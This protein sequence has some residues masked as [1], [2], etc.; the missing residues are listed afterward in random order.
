M[1]SWLLAEA[2]LGKRPWT[3]IVPEGVDDLTLH[4]PDREF[5]AQLKSRHDPKAVFD[6]GEVARFLAK[7][8]L[9]LPEG[10]ANDDRYALAVV[11]ERPV[12]GLEAGDFDRTIGEIDQDLSPLVTALQ[13][14]LPDGFDAQALLER[15]YL[16][17]EANPIRGASL[18]LAQ[19]G[20]EPAILNIVAQML[21]EAAGKA[22]DD[23]YRAGAT[24]VAMLGRTDV[25]AR[26]DL[27]R[28]L[29]DPAGYLALTAGLAELAD[30]T[31]PLPVGGFYEGVNTA[32]GHVGAGLVFERPEA[33]ADVL[34]ALEERRAVLI[35]GPSGAGKSAL[36][37]LAAHH[38]RHAVRWYRLRGLL[39]A[40]VGRVAELARRLDANPDRPVGFVVDDV[41]RDDTAG[42]DT[43]VREAE[44]NPGVLLIG[45]VREEDLFLLSTASRTPT[46]RPILTPVLAEH[47]WTAL[48]RTSELKFPY[49]QEPFD[50][51][52]GLLLEYLHLLTA[53]RRLAQTIAEQVRRRLA[54][55]RGAELAVLRAVAFASSNGA[56]VDP[57][58]LRARE[59]IDA[60]SFAKALKRLVD[61]HAV[62]MRTDGAIAGLHEI[63]SAHLDQAI[64][65]L[66]GEPRDVAVAAA[67][68]TLAADTF[69]A[70]IPN[71]L[72]TW[73]DVSGALFN[74]LV[75][76]LA[77]PDA[78]GW[79]NI[80]HGLG[81]ATAD[82][83]AKRWLEISRE[84]E[85]ED[86][87]SGTMFGLVMAGSEMGD[88][89]IFAGFNKAQRAFKEV[90]I[91]DLRQLVVDR[92][93]G[94]P[95][96]P[97]L[98]LSTAHELTAALLSIHGATAPPSLNIV[99]DGDLSQGNLLELTLLLE[100]LR[101]RDLA[102]AERVIAAAGGVDALLD[103]V[104]HETDWATRPEHGEFDGQPAVTAH[105]RHIHTEVQPDIHAAALELCRR[106]AAVTPHAERF[107][108][109]AI[110]ADG[111]PAGMGE[112]RLATL[113][114]IRRAFP[115]PARVAWNRA[116]LRALTRLVAT[117]S[118]T[119]RTTSLA[120]TIREI[121]DGVRQAGDF[122]CRGQ[123]PGAFWLGLLQIRKLLTSFVAPPSVDETHGGPLARGSLAG[124]DQLHSFVV[125][126]QRLM[127]ELTD[128][129]SESPTLMA[130]RT[131]DLARDALALQDPT[132]WR[133]TAQPP[134]AE[135]VE[136]ETTL[137]E[138]RAVLGDAAEDPEGHRTA[139]LRFGAT[140]RRHNILRR[141]AEAARARTEATLERKRETIKTAF[142]A[143]GLAVEVATKPLDKDR[144]WKWPDA[145]YA[146]MLVVESLFDFPALEPVFAE[147]AAQ[148]E[149]GGPLTFAP[150]VHGFV[151]PFA[152]TFISSVLPDIEF[153]PNWSGRLPFP[154][155]PDDD[156]RKLFDR[157][158]DAVVT[159]SSAMMERGRGRN[160]AETAFL[161]VLADRYSQSVEALLVIANADGDALLSEALGLLGRMG[162]RLVDEHEASAG[163]DTLALECT[164][165]MRGEMTEVGRELMAARLL[166]MER[167]AIHAAAS[168]PHASA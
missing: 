101:D 164:R 85:I 123:R 78:S 146:A 144:G 80:F 36:A 13:T 166:L 33:M 76:R 133:N 168:R 58:R 31:T 43:L 93:P 87:H 136:L 99:P 46:V 114:P 153:G 129:V 70:F 79:I 67:T 62:R 143:R 11:L 95:N 56:A 158:V 38:S 106:L 82:E 119:Q 98:D 40:D 68:A 77:S 4:G 103:R 49:W 113:R 7:A 102:L 9:D 104:Y 124:N 48:S 159:T 90:A 6:L 63:R 125:G 131:A 61:E 126:L 140:S 47:I 149:L 35:A 75:E 83:I 55:D 24:K 14:A 72:R 32:P 155:L 34:G 100:T 10:W 108:C 5:R 94:A 65:D 157:A 74:G 145:E 110:W 29:I 91:Q 73:P 66:L 134:I 57:E 71:V 120:S 23:N 139:A 112:Y 27:A 54:E 121:A 162:Q 12:A 15:S 109:N 8:A 69:G 45:T 59:D 30:F 96:L 17:V 39:V 132:V 130:A 88:A 26:L 152:F 148:L 122:Y 41:G 115:S 89:E 37:W 28:S 163:T 25:Q 97:V 116:Q 20:L 142:A 52:Q 60:I 22:A 154:A 118:D 21:R 84:A 50:Q 92:L 161:D 151:P 19:S 1:G 127:T 117:T 111:L 167:A 42:W 16:I 156:V 3:T 160:D 137:W 44:T 147:L 150:I 138:I 53:G 81:L 2:W 128:G 105:L 165:M 141:A 64:Q 18:A 135:L 107:V 86:R 51:S